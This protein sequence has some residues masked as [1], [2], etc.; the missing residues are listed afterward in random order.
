VG[1]RLPG[2]ASAKVVDDSGIVEV[3]DVVL[4]VDDIVVEV[5]VVEVVDE[6]V[7]EVDVDVDGEVV[8]DVEPVDPDPLSVAM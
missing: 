8:L 1:A 7:V 3:V 2:V 6:L 4:V 5:D